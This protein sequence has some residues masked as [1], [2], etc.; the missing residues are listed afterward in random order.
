M[1]KIE[2]VFRGKNIYTSIKYYKDFLRSDQFWIILK[3]TI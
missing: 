2:T 3:T 1:V